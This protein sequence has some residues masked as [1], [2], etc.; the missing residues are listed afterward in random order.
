MTTT[1][2]TH[3]PPHKFPLT[4]RLHSGKTG[5]IV[6]SRTV[7]LEEARILAKIEIPSFAQSAHYP[8]RAEIEYADGTIDIE[9]MQ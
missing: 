3:L 2:K 8:V 9:G 4:I 7:T 5:E 1:P 6:W